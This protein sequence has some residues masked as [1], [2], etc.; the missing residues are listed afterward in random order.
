MRPEKDEAKAEAEAEAEAKKISVRPRPKHM[1]PKPQ[2]LKCLMNHT[3]Y[4]YVHITFI[5]HIKP[6]SVRQN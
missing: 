3:T 1:R 2:C 4:K 5:L 6:T